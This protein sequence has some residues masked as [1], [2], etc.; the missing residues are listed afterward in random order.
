MQNGVASFSFGIITRMF[1]HE[2]PT[3]VNRDDNEVVSTK[4]QKVFIECDWF[5]QV[6]INPLIGLT[7]I[8]YNPNWT[9]SRYVLLE[10]CLSKNCVFWP[11]N[12]FTPEN[13]KCKTF[14]LKNQQYT[15]HDIPP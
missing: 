13:R 6:G 3:L 1:I 8:Q 15:E 5:E 11:Y 4:L 2:L 10:K 14:N 9:G 7:I 12:P